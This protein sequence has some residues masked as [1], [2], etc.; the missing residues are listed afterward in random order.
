MSLDEFGSI[1]KKLRTAAGLSQDDVAKKLAISRQSISKWELGISLPDIIYLVPLTKILDC[2][3]EELLQIKRKDVDN[4]ND[5]FKI[6]MRKNIDRKEYEVL[7]KIYGN[8]WLDRSIDFINTSYYNEDFFVLGY[9]NN[10]VISTVHITKH[11]EQID[12]YLI[13]DLGFKEGHESND[14]A[15]SMIDSV[16]SILK[17]LNCIKVGAFVEENYKDVFEKFGFIKLSDDYEFGNDKKCTSCADPYYEMNIKQD[18]YCEEINEA[19]ANIVSKV[20]MTKKYKYCKDVSDYFKSNSFMFMQ[21]L[22]RENKFDNE[23]VY[24]IMNGKIICGYTKMFY[25][26]DKNLYLRIDLREECLFNAAVKTAIDTAKD[27]ANIVKEKIIIENIVFYVNDNLLLKEE[28]DFYKKALKENN[29][30][31]DDNIKF[32][33]KLD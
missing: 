23:K 6:L 25:E 15:S 22:L 27:Y 20:I 2:E 17:D 10:E 11:P 31:T 8:R 1:L 7:K 4:M 24:V 13:S 26:E 3:I 5:N 12:F 28:F 33:F 18:Y 9:L 19:N 21:N 29:F 30:I 16:L 32:I 14:L